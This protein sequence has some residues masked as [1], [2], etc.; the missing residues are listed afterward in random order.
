MGSPPESHN[1]TTPCSDTL[2]LHFSSPPSLPEPESGEMTPMEPR[3]L[4]LTEPRLRPTELQTPPT[5]P[6]HTP[7]TPDWTSPP[8]LSLSSP[9]SV[10]SFSSPPTSP[11]PPSEGRERPL[12]TPERPTWLRG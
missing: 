9:S 1:T 12:R 3:S 2:L 11:C 4:T 7:P 10:S 6:P 8:S 5:P